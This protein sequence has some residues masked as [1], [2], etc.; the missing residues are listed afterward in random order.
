MARDKVVDGHEDG[1]IVVEPARKMMMR[2]EIGGSC[3][4]FGGYSW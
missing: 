3:F 1:R 4:F 2:S